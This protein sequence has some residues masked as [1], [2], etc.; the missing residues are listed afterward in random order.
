MTL[1]DIGFFPVNGLACPDIVIENGQIKEDNTLETVVL[2][3]LFSDALV[4]Q[5]ELNEGDMDR[6]GWWADEFSQ[7]SD[8]K[9]GSI[10]WL[11][12]RG[13]ATQDTV[14]RIEEGALEA[15]Q[16]MIDDGV[17]ASVEATAVRTELERIDLSVNI[18]RPEGD[19]IPFKFI[20]DAQSLRRA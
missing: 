9:I 19:S 13:K 16:W 4:T 10:L 3:S 17:A 15:L 1:Q 12:D 2:I 14:N 7:A 20:W 6:R 18:F 11:F 5:E 8:D